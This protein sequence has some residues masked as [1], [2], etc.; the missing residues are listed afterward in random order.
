MICVASESLLTN[1]AIIKI[2]GPVDTET[3]RR[4]LGNRLQLSGPLTEIAENNPRSCHPWHA[5]KLRPKVLLVTLRQPC[6]LS[7]ARYTVGQTHVLKEDER[8][9]REVSIQK[10]RCRRVVTEPE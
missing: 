4:G 7:A 5:V 10:S 2:A 6:V 1:R 8:D 3:G 9:V